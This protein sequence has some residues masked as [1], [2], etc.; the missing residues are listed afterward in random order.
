[1]KAKKPHIPKATQCNYE[2]ALLCANQSFLSITKVGEA[3]TLFIR[4]DRSIMHLLARLRYL[5]FLFAIEKLE[6]QQ[7]KLANFYEK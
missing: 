4:I 6:K 5:C 7:L 2:R 1:M 3:V